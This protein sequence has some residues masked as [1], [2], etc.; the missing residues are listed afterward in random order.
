[1]F[2]SLSNF[3][4]SKQSSIQWSCTILQDKLYIPLFFAYITVIISILCLFLRKY[5]NS[6]QPKILFRKFC[7]SF[8]IN[9]PKAKECLGSNISS[10]FGL[11]N[12]NCF[13][14]MAPLQFEHNLWNRD[15]AAVLKFWHILNRLKHGGVIIL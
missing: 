1:M 6:N 2:V 12:Q 9:Q 7:L 8:Y 13:E 15:L 3:A 11:P 14:D 4:A 10:E 5:Q